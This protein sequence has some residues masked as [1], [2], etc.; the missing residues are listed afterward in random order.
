MD[1]RL[2]NLKR[3]LAS[4]PPLPAIHRTNEVSHPRPLAPHHK[5]YTEH[6]EMSLP[7]PFSKVLSVQPDS[8]EYEIR[9]AKPDLWSIQQREANVLARHETD[10]AI[11]SR[12]VRKRRQPHV[13][14]DRVR[15]RQGPPPDLLS[16]D[17]RSKRQLDKEASK[18]LLPPPSFL[19]MFEVATQE[20]QVASNET[21]NK[22]TNMKA[23]SQRKNIFVTKLV[24]YVCI[25]LSSLRFMKNRS[26]Q[27]ASVKKATSSSPRIERTDTVRRSRRN[28]NPKAGCHILQEDQRTGRQV[29][30]VE[31]RGVSRRASL[32][33]RA[34]SAIAFTVASSSVPTPSKLFP[35][36]CSPF[37]CSTTPLK[38]DF[39]NGDGV[40]R[41]HS[42]FALGK[43]LETRA[44]T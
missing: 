24:T 20:V 34:A 4:I 16:V 10:Q 31:G 17:Y 19:K 30:E 6:Q 41:R 27:F 21:L 14:P 40:H 2:Q 7:K 3:G 26:S 13:R 35:W 39:L 44:S 5:A 9:I 36:S 32:V 22:S 11:I 33:I 38:N 42:I 18:F 37:C 8:G 15:L 25:W 23:K 43:F 28:A 12:L 1:T 29:S